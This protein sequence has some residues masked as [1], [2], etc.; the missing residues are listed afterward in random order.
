MPAPGI[1]IQSHPTAT[2]Y[3][4]PK[5]GDGPLQKEFEDGPIFEFEDGENYDFQNV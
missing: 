5:A 1:N 3:E 4:Y 2:L